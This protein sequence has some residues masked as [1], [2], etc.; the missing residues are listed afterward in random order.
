[1]AGPSF[2][3]THQPLW[4]S[5][6][7]GNSNPWDLADLLWLDSCPQQVSEDMR[8]R[9]IEWVK[10][11]HANRVKPYLKCV[12]L[13]LKE[14]YGDN[15]LFNKMLHQTTKHSLELDRCASY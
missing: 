13:L 2:A 5:N 15:I 3:V 7:V 4:Q 14:S 10:P 12:H 6:P 8:R 1:M 9:H 11:H